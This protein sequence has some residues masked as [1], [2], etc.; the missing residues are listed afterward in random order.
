MK[1]IDFDETTLPPK[2]R[3][4]PKIKDLIDNEEAY[5]AYLKTEKDKVLAHKLEA[6]RIQKRWA[7]EQ[8]K[9]IE[10][11][12]LRMFEDMIIIARVLKA[13]ENPDSKEYDDP[14]P[15]KSKKKK[16]TKIVKEEQQ[17]S[18]VQFE[19]IIE[20][21]ESESNENNDHEQLVLF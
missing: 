13:E 5:V 12:V 7:V 19:E 18:E 4:H 14:K 21:D 8:E 6:T 3:N 11:D 9:W 20:A 16:E 17:D 1:I 15:R 10:Y 2:T